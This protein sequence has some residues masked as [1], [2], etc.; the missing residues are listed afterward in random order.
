[1]SHDSTVNPDRVFLREL[2][3]LRDDYS[4]TD[5]NDND[6]DR[7]KEEISYIINHLCIS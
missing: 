1:M 2:C 7:T 4:L 3:L 5:N 6:C